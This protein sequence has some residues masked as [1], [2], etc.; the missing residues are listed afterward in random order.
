MT[1]FPG[2]AADIVD[3]DGKSVGKGE[4]GY[5]VISQRWPSMLRGILARP[6]ALQRDLLV[7]TRGIYFAG[8]GAK[9]DEDGD[10]WLLGRINVMNISGH[11]ISTTE[12][13]HALVGHPKVHRSRSRRCERPDHRPGDRRLRHGEGQRARQR[14]RRRGARG[15][16]ACACRQ[17]DRRDRKT[18]RHP[19]QS[20]PAEDAVGKIMRR[21]LRD[22]ADHRTLGDT[23]TLLDPNVVATI[24]AQM[25]ASTEE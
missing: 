24:A 19:D 15:R 10:F 25:P 9:K 5:M 23:T 4:G 16:A 17:G 20:R 12:V 2:I 13:E 8:D 7:H 14:I 22:V 6:R 18:A 3:N 11:R 1:A 21:L